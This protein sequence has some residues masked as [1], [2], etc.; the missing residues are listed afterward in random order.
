VG[1]PLPRL[2][3]HLLLHLLLCFEPRAGRA[4]A[5]RLCQPV[6]LQTFRRGTR[7][8]VCD[9]RAAA[10]L[11]TAPVRLPRQLRWLPSRPLHRARLAARLAACLAARRGHRA[12]RPRAHHPR[13]HLL[14][15]ATHA[16]AGRAPRGEG[17]PAAYATRSAA[18]RGRL[19]RRRRWRR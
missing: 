13:A 1:Q 4:S 16:A 17:R 2:L 15:H 11:A 19:R 9:A 7:R 8:D 6:R 3:L 10:R 18:V 5:H 12:R 14:A